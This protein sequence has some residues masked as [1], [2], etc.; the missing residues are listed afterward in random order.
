VYGVA[1][2]LRGGQGGGNYRVDAAR[3]WF[4]TERTKSFPRN[5]EV[6]SVLTFTSDAPAA[7]A[8]RVAPDAGAMVFEQHHSL[9]VLPDTTGFRPRD[10]DGAPATAARSSPT[11]RSASTAVSRRLHQP[12]APGAQGPRGVRAR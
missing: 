10:Y 2:G 1:G 4:D 12:L 6:H 8:R 7:T 9:I 11:C 3:S 5:A